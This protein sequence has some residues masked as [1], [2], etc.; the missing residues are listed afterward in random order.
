MHNWWKTRTVRTDTS[1]R[2]FSYKNIKRER[3]RLWHKRTP[4]E[5]APYF[6]WP[7]ANSPSPSPHRACQVPV[8]VVHDKSSFQDYPRVL[9]DRFQH[10]VRERKAIYDVIYHPSTFLRERPW[11]VTLREEISHSGPNIATNT[12][13]EQLGVRAAYACPTCRGEVHVDPKYEE[14]LLDPNIYVPHGV[15]CECS[16]GQSECDANCIEAIYSIANLD[17]RHFRQEVM[18][19]RREY[20]EDSSHTYMSSVFK[21]LGIEGLQHVD[22]CD[23]QPE[24]HYHILR[25]YIPTN[26]CYIVHAAVAQTTNNFSDVAAMPEA[27]RMHANETPPRAFGSPSAPMTMLDVEHKKCQLKDIIDISNKFLG[28][29]PRDTTKVQI[30]NA[31][32]TT[33]ASDVS[34]PEGTLTVTFAPEVQTLPRRIRRVR[35]NHK[36]PDIDPLKRATAAN[37]LNTDEPIYQNPVSLLKRRYPLRQPPL[38]PVVPP[39]PRFSPIPEEPQRRYDDGYQ[40]PAPIGC[41]RSQSTEIIGKHSDGDSNSE[42]PDLPHSV[43]DTALHDIADSGCYQPEDSLRYDTYGNRDGDDV[44]QLAALPQPCHLENGNDDGQRQ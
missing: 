22:F 39:P 29:L 16:K 28:L 40:R 36:L 32:E 15:K 42:Y 38:P 20:K 3:E 5:Y 21:S 26:A 44:A 35:C 17:R 34:S 37:E 12:F 4:R 7:E 2:L 31:T 13:F 18:R 27:T 25:E 33:T 1:T 30:E 6:T 41:P 8:L 43:S 24:P 10:V 14:P 19:A 11:L 23:E 9:P